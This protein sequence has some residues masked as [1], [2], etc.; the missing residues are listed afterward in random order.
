VIGNK[1]KRKEMEKTKKDETA[2]PKGSYMLIARKVGCT[3]KYVSLVLN[4]KLG[5]YQDR[6]T[7]MVHLIRKA[8]GELAEVLKPLR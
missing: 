8:A 5:K 4:D 1:V 3:S 6:E 7:E 2:L